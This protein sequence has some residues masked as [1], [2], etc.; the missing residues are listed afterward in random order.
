VERRR[1]G[2]LRGDA[3]R[4]SRA[5]GALMGVRKRRDRLVVFRLTQEEYRR[6]QRESSRNG[7]RS[8]SDYTRARLLEADRAGALS[9]RQVEKRLAR[10]DER[11]DEVQKVLRQVARLVKKISEM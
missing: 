1:G 10:F 6:L 11:L 3:P 5:T 9:A 7:A 8:L 4:G 2:D